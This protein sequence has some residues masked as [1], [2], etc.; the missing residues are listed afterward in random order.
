M[1]QL[2]KVHL[3]FLSYR[4][5]T[6]VNYLNHFSVTWS[7]GNSREVC[8][9][10]VR[11]TQGLGSNTNFNCFFNL[12]RHELTHSFHSALARLKLLSVLRSFFFF[13]VL[14]RDSK[15]KSSKVASENKPPKFK[16]SH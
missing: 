3:V 10:Q 7:N 16:P 13:N 4:F 15:R 1:S 9:Y 12:M 14:K 8:V 5:S 6:T 2:P 11:V